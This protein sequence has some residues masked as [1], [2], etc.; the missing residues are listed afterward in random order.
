[1]N[2][3][4]IKENV[5]RMNEDKKCIFCGSSD[6]IVECR[7]EWLCEGCYGKYYDKPAISVVGI[8]PIEE[9]REHLIKIARDLTNKNG[10]F[11]EI[12]IGYKDG[13]LNIVDARIERKPNELTAEK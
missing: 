1:M 10:Y 4:D 11:C 3:D 9:I 12:S 2:W 6:F 8:I 13:E 5:M 7:G